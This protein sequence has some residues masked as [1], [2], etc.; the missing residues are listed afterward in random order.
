M[1]ENMRETQQDVPVMEVKIST[2]DLT[3]PKP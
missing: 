3:M 2:K 1:A